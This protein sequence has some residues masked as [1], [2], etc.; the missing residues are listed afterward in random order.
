MDLVAGDYSKYD[1]K[2][3]AA[4]PTKAYL[5]RFGDPKIDPRQLQV[6]FLK[7]FHSFYSKYVS[8]GDSKSLLEFGGGP[9]LF[10]LLSAAKH[11]ESITFADYAES[12]R[13]E[14]LQW[15]EGASER[16]FRNGSRNP[17]KVH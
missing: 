13:K 16:K 15:R 14:I 1:S 6:N 10:S 4:F 3:N 9:A 11:V 17:A 2:I 12:N 8:Q 7:G 5:E